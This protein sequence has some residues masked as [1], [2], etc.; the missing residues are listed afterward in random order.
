MAGKVDSFKI[1]F[2][3]TVKF[4]YISLRKKKLKTQTLVTQAHIIFKSFIFIF[5]FD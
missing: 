3:A 4:M 2:K 5:S 1:R